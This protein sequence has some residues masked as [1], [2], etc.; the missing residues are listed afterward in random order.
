MRRGE[1]GQARQALGGVLRVALPPGPGQARQRA[2]TVV[3]LRFAQRA[4]IARQ[5]D[6][7]ARM[8]PRSKLVLGV[9]ELKAVVEDV[10]VEHVYCWG[11]G[12]LRGA[13]LGGWAARGRKMRLRFVV[14]R[15]EGRRT[16]AR[17]P[18]V[19]LPSMR[20]GMGAAARRRRPLSLA[21][22]R[23]N[24]VLAAPS[25]T[26]EPERRWIH[27]DRASRNVCYAIR[28]NMIA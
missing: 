26:T 13:A 8:G 2:Q 14:G 7:T 28:R 27:D 12:A 19:V 9:Q 3:T 1:A 15:D 21:L 4:A 23:T 6:A 11:G 17:G 22:L 5:P 18:R 16:A 25:S 24:V 20:A 10:V